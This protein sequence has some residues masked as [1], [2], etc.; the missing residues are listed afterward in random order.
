M[1]YFSTG[2]SAA[3]NGISKARQA[4]FI[5]AL[6][7]KYTK[8]QS[9]IDYNLRQLE[10]H[11][12]KL[13]MEHHKRKVCL[14]IVVSGVCLFIA[15]NFLTGSMMGPFYD[16]KKDDEKRSLKDLAESI[17]RVRLRRQQSLQENDIVPTAGR[18]VQQKKSGNDGRQ[19]ENKGWV[20]GNMIHPPNGLEKGGNSLETRSISDEHSAELIDEENLISEL[21]N[22]SNIRSEGGDGLKQIEE[23]VRLSQ[24]IRVKEE[25][26]A[27]YLED[28]MAASLD[29]LKQYA[30]NLPPLEHPEI[31]AESFS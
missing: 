7:N 20:M 30:G 9:Q 1:V 25:L 13:L 23:R 28:K 2:T 21:E 12:S 19:D 22:E 27:K 18:G 29:A 16:A 6:D 17:R 31:E 11:R 3:L 15:W 10:I 8:R 5:S 24:R 4:T 26:K 14:Y